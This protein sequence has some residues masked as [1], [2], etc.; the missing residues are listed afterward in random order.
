MT[1]SCTTSTFWS[2]RITFEL[3]FTTNKTSSQ[4]FCLVIRRGGHWSIHATQSWRNTTFLSRRSD[5]GTGRKCGK[6]FGHRFG[7]DNEME[8]GQANLTISTLGKGWWH[9][10][11]FNERKNKQYFLFVI[12]HAAVATRFQRIALR[13]DLT[14]NSALVGWWCERK[15]SLIC[16]CP[17]A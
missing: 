14:A 1:Q 3:A 7:R 5:V 13:A 16:N 4:S 9:T 11:F 17:S 12:S 8:I 6:E 2:C 10:Q 15:D